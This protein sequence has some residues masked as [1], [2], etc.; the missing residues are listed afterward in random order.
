MAVPALWH[1][2]LH[3]TQAVHRGP[4]PGHSV[5]KSRSGDAPMSCQGGAREH[6]EHFAGDVALEAAKDLALG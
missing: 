6:L 1:E 4:K 3:Q 5:F 2:S